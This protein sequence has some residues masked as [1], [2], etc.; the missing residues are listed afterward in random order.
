MW[1]FPTICRYWHKFTRNDVINALNGTENILSLSNCVTGANIAI[2]SQHFRN[3]ANRVPNTS[4]H[5]IHCAHGKSI[6]ERLSEHVK[7]RIAYRT[8]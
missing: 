4:F 5:Y 7:D 8:I 1:I 6:H 3:N 2:L